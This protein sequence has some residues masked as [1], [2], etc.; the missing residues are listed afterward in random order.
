MYITTFCGKRIDPLNVKVSDIEIVDIAHALSHICRFG[1]HTRSFYSV[2][3]HSCRVAELVP[4]EF[5][6]PA[7]LHDGAEAYLGDVITPLKKLLPVYTEIE[8][9]FMRAIAARF[10]IDHLI[11]K[12][13][14]DAD[15]L[16]FLVEADQY[17]FI[18]PIET[19]TP[20]PDSFL[21][22]DREMPVSAGFAKDRFLFQFAQYLKC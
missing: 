9:S 4:P 7:L 13:V 3:Q 15:W 1:G 12:P 5:K 2:A 8:E 14:K 21:T 10:E 17:T 22:V 20:I 19:R 16:M 11:P 18:N 6:M